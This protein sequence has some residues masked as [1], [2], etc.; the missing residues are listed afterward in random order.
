MTPKTTSGRSALRQRG[1]VRRIAGGK[2]A[3]AAGAPT[4]VGGG[5][6]EKLPA[7]EGV[8]PGS[9]INTVTCIYSHLPPW[10]R[11]G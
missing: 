4:E 3:G 10:S 9:R 11:V 6:R 7:A 1:T 8:Y 5:R 2:P